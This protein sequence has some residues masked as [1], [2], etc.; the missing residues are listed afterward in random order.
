MLRSVSGLLATLCVLTATAEEPPAN[1]DDWGTFKADRLECVIGNNVAWGD[2]HR[3]RYNG[4]FK[5]TSPDCATGTDRIA[6]VVAARPEAEIVVNVQ[7][8][9]PLMPPAGLSA[10]SVIASMLLGTHPPEMDGRYLVA[11]AKRFGI[12]EGTARV[13]LSRMVDRG[14]LE[15][16]SG[17]YRLAGHLARRQT[18]QDAARASITVDWDG[19]WIQAVAVG[20]AAASRRTER[21]AEFAAAKL[22]VKQEGSF[23]RFAGTVRLDPIRLEHSSVEVEI[24]TASIQAEPDRLESHLRDEHDDLLQR[25]LDDDEAFLIAARRLGRSETLGIVMMVGAACL[26]VIGMLIIRRIVKIEI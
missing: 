13:A 14:E 23:G 15:N 21:R 17:R 5:M 19:S 4:I 18:R 2:T 12:A 11:L 8:D 24:E 20:K 6:E 3:E 7:G 25:G 22:T 1:S 9:E 16:R 10:R 26:Q